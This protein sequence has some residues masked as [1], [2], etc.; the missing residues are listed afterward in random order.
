VADVLDTVRAAFQGERVASIYADG[1]VVEVAVSAQADLRRDPE[2]VGNLLL[3]S[4]SGF[5]VPLSRVA[6]VYLTDGAARVS[7]DDGLPRE[8]VTVTSRMAGFAG[9]AREALARVQPPAGVYYELD[10]PASAGDV[11]TPLAVGYALALFAVA[12]L[13]AV[14]FD[15]RTGVLMLA[16]ASLALVG[17]AAAAFLLG[18]VLSIG[19][20]AGL[21][22]LFGLG[23]RH[24]IMLADRLDAMVL[25]Q[26]APWSWETVERAA[27]E[28][29]APILVTS[30]LIALALAPLAVH[31]GA[32][33][34]EVLGPM[35]IV[36]LCGLLTSV[37]GNLFILPVLAHRFWRPGY[38]RRAKRAET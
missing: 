2:T 18:G 22:A 13:L 11:A 10:D 17:G 14:A 24:A 12:V 7:H 20:V 38:G 33:G 36:I 1:R 19:V 23:L 3:R 28:R 9:A 21:I 15:P 26:H 37:A 34:R 5:S 8:A 16:S 25:V 32:P 30:V 29:L 4:S 35:A 27:Q 31:A 6:D